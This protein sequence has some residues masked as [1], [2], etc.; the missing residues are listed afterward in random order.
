M[1]AV[2]RLAFDSTNQTLRGRRLPAD[3]VD[4]WMDCNAKV[5]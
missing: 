4:V 2:H 1:D 5:V 3:Y